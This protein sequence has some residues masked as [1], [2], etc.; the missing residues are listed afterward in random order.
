MPR[1][2]QHDTLR[3]ALRLAFI[4]SIT[5]VRNNL[6]AQLAA[7][8][9][10]ELAEKDSLPA[11]QHQV[12]VLDQQRLRAADDGRLQVSVAVAVV[13][14]VWLRARRELLEE[15]VEVLGQ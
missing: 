11:P 1:C 3:P 9:A 5:L 12:A 8:G 7:P 14:M 13:M 10:I 15:S 4:G 6:D 2:A